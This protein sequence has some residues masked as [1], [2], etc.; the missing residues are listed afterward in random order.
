M[1]TT[2]L[3]IASQSNGFIP[4]ST[5]EVIAYIRRPEMF[6]LNRYVQYVPA[7]Q[8]VGVY[9]LLGRDEMIRIVSDGE[10]DFADGDEAPQGVYNQVPFFTQEFACK[11]RAYPWRLG[12]I[13]IETADRGRLWKPKIAHMQMALSKA[14]TNRSNRV[15]SLI[16][17]NN[18]G[19]SHTATAKVLNGSTA[20]G[21]WSVASSDPAST[22]Y[23]NIW[24]SLMAAAK[25]IHLDTNGVVQPT[26]LRVLV[27][28]DDA[29]AV[30]QAP[31]LVDYVKQQ[32]SAVQLVE[33]GWDPQYTK[34]GLPRSYKGFEFVVED[35]PIVDVRPNVA[36]LTNVADPLHP[37]EAAVTTGAAGRHYMWPKGTAIMCSRIGALDGEYGAPSFSTLQVFHYG[38]LLEV[39][40]F[41]DPQNERI[42]GRVQ[43]FYVEKIV[44]NVSGFR[45]TSI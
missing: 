41:D 22:E 31:E 2:T 27:G 32:P 44:S 16:T 43:E 24:K 13:A 23:L 34:W 21:T 7:P 5:G 6:P 37:V 8:P 40:A 36:G 14:M 42:K 26:D 15:I 19:T 11:R 17:G 39:K 3:R 20:T 9:S 28:P 12:H 38:G 25:T 10:F 29:I 4:E 30:S 35:S 18:Y 1:P 45:I 33:G